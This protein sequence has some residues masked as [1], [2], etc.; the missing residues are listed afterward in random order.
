MSF[1]SESYDITI[2]EQTMCMSLVQGSDCSV[3]RPC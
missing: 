1:M 3:V 2:L